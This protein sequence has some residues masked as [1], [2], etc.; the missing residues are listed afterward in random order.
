MYDEASL[1]ELE[2]LSE[3]AECLEEL[4]SGYFI[5]SESESGWEQSILE[6]VPHL[7]SMARDQEKVRIFA[8]YLLQYAS[9]S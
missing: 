6:Q 4:D 8:L 7:F 3:L 9:K 1:G 2:S 5:G